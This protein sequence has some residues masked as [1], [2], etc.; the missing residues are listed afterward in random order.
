MRIFKV[1][2][3]TITFVIS[4]IVMGLLAL[5]DAS[6]IVLMV[7]GAMTIAVLVAMATQLKK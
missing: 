5:L 7:L 3:M 2:L 6:P 4:L 1:L